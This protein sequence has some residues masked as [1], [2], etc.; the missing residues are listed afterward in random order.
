MRRWPRRRP[1]PPNRKQKAVLDKFRQTQKAW[2]YYAPNGAQYVLG[3]VEGTPLLPRDMFTMMMFNRLFNVTLTDGR[4]LWPMPAITDVSQALDVLGSNEGDILKRGPDRWSAVPDSGGGGTSLVLALAGRST[5]YTA[6]GTGNFAVRLDT[7]RHDPQGWFSAADEGFIPDRA[8]WYAVI[9]RVETTNDRL[10]YIWASK[11]GGNTT[12]IGENSQTDRVG[13]GGVGIIEV[14]GTTDVIG[15]RA[16]TV[17]FGIIDA[18]EA[19]TYLAIIGP[20]A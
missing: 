1:G 11:N 5:N 13:F 15:L 17:S 8:G 2:A 10:R 3:Q 14:N 4:T 16:G 12:L 9:G 20:F 18:R 19:R 7:A 6:S